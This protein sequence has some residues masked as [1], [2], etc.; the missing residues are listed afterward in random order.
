MKTLEKPSKSH[1]EVSEA[2]KRKILTF[3]RMKKHAKLLSDKIEMMKENII[4]ELGSVECIA[5]FEEYKLATLSLESKLGIDK[6]KLER[7]FPRVFEKVQKQGKEYFVL[8]T[9]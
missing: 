9:H 5:I 4:E 1:V 8:R 3:A 2:T 6:E 7:D